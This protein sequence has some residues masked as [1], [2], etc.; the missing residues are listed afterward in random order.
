M[1]WPIKCVFGV[2]LG[3][4]LKPPGPKKVLFLLGSFFH[5]EGKCE[6][7]WDW[8]L[9]YQAMASKLGQTG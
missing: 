3:Q 5:C 7:E 1:G 4:E 8:D 2:G 6:R 9:P